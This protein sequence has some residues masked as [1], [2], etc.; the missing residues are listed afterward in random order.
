MALHGYDKTKLRHERDK[1]MEIG[2]LLIETEVPEYIHLII[3]EQ[4]REIELILS[5]G[6]DPRLEG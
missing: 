1:L 2:D 3:G 5:H 6:Q 4:I